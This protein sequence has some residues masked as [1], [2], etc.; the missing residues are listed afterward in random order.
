[1]NNNYRLSPSKYQTILINH[2]DRLV[3]FYIT[4]YAEKTEYQDF[5]DCLAST[6]DILISDFVDKGISLEDIKK[7]NI[8]EEALD[9]FQT[10]FSYSRTPQNTF[11]SNE[12]TEEKHKLISTVIYE[13]STGNSVSCSHN[14]CDIKKE[15]EATIGY[16]ESF[17]YLKV[18]FPCLHQIL[19][20]DILS[21]PSLDDLIPLINNAV[22]SNRRVRID[23]KVKEAA[24]NDLLNLTEFYPER[25]FLGLRYIFPETQGELSYGELGFSMHHLTS[26]DEIEQALR[27]IH[28]QHN[29]FKA[30][31]HHHEC[32]SRI[33]LQL[34]RI[35]SLS[36]LPCRNNKYIK[37]LN[38]IEN[39]FMALSAWRMV[40]LIGMSRAEAIDA[41]F[42]RE[43]QR[44]NS[45]FA[46]SETESKKKIRDRLT[47]VEKFIKAQGE[48]LDKLR[49]KYL[50]M[51][52]EY[53][54]QE[55][56]EQF[57]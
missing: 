14:R 42:K 11:S 46:T 22:K 25:L 36:L 28:Y 48:Y 49:D 31:Y 57:T 15:D 55:V 19:A 3:D 30:Y 34:G 2:L 4:L 33:M 7:Y 43:S 56:T 54:T 27:D 13:L 45:L 39:T 26:D 5:K 6:R 41:V 8:E 1:M 50:T 24:M 47:S 35:T 23:K 17:S 16:K 20:S 51:H 52:P 12:N 10:N 38:S 37:Q 44:D 18:L 29:K 9:I 40:H 21:S 53:H 32:P